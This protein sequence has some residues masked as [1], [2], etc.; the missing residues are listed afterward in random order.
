MP[1]RRRGAT[2]ET[3]YEDGDLRAGGL[4]RVGGALRRHRAPLARR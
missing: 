3:A 1:D 2:M 4:W